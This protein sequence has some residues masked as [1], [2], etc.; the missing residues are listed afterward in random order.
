MV[1]RSVYQ[2][3]AEGK[4]FT[5]DTTVALPLEEGGCVFPKND[6]EIRG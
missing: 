3:P 2:L 5:Q 4:T 1:H 6:P